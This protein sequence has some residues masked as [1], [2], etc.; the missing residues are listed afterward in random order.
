MPEGCCLFSNAVMHRDFFKCNPTNTG[1]YQYPKFEILSYDEGCHCREVNTFLEKNDTDKYVIFYTRHTNLSGIKKNKIV[2][3]F[4][5]GET[6]DEPKRGFCASETVLLPKDKCIGIDYKGRGVPVSWGNSSIK[7]KVDSILYE[8]K[9]NQNKD[10][11]VQYQKETKEIM[12]LLQTVS[13]RKKII[14]KCE[15]CRV[16]TQCYW[17]KKTRER[18]EKTLKELYGGNQV[19]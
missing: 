11:S 4:K 7:N 17:G 13:G 18:K 3:Y 10:I 15:K 9:T 16:K 2:G 6:F 14:D 8:M 1:H 5:V 19:C 12:K